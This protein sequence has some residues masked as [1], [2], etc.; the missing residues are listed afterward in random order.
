MRLAEA[1]EVLEAGLYGG[2]A[3]F[4]GVSTDSRRDCGGKLFVALPGENFD[5][6][7]YVA[8]AAAAG[9]AAALTERRV[10][11]GIPE[12]VVS[13]SRRSLVRLAWRQRFDVPVVAVTGS[14]GKTTVKE[15]IAAILGRRHRVLAT[16]GNLN[17]DIGVAATLFGLNH[18]H[19][20]AVVEMGANH[21]GE[22]A[23]LAR[24]CPP[25]V[26]VVTQCAP[27]HLEGFGDVAGVA[28]AKGELFESL[29]PAG[30]G[31]V[32]ADDA[33][34]A[35]WTGLLRGRTVVRFG[36]ES[37]A[38]V[39]ATFAS[40]TGGEGSRIELSTPRGETTVDLALPGRHNVMNALAACAAALGIGESLDA[41]REGLEGM[42]PISGRLC[43]RSL[44]GGS[45][46]LDDTYNANPGSLRAA[47]E[48]LEARGGERWLVLGDMAELGRD[49]SGLHAE[50]GRLARER[51]VSRLY[52]VGPLTV[53]AVTAFGS[54]ARHHPTQADLIA[55]LRAD[56]RDE[57][58][59]TVLVKGSRSMGME[60]VVQALAG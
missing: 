31:V 44:A 30:V 11:V 55:D 57:A 58:P 27:A 23:G 21:P 33:F 47:L 60:C 25:R 43:E 19:R 51:G 59:V 18:R 16:A 20:R 32:N 8:A 50:A 28:Q 9:A 48:V 17:T 4:T 39:R 40:R 29:P 34:A 46:L 7:D 10:D 2:D 5:G 15:M 6:H 26:A 22:I 45:V 53:E 52:G 13:D 38:E 1:R 37:P 24:L 49:G 3:R 36:L 54:S 35:F 56:L 14:N 41:V 12:L 42:R